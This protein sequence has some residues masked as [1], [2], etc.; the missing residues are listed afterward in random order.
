MGCQNSKNFQNWLAV[1]SLGTSGVGTSDR[2][3]HLPSPKKK[4]NQ[5]EKKRNEIP[6]ERSVR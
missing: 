4:I 6:V 5:K 3:K 2:Y 1:K